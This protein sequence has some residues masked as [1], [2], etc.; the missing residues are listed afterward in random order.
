M[1]EEK[2]DLPTRVD[3]VLG[4]VERLA[5]FLQT[6]SRGDSHIA[7]QAGEVIAELDDIERELK[8]RLLEATFE[9]NRLDRRITRASESERE[10]RRLVAPHA[11]TGGDLADLPPGVRD[12]LRKAHR[13]RTDIAVWK[14]E[15]E[16]AEEAIRVCRAFEA[17]LSESRADLR[18]VLDSLERR[19]RAA[20]TKHA[21]ARLADRLRVMDGQVRGALS[22]QVDD[23]AAGAE[24]E[25]EVAVN[26]E[27]LRIRELYR[28]G[29]D[30]AMEEDLRRLRED[31]P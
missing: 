20:E 23:A 30:A 31:P 8:G 25:H 17:L 10:L 16:E 13:L 27:E 28:L 1:T 2:R 21:L 24:A 19:F 12:A 26:H 6:A 3:D 29:E 18:R 9:R 4:V 7:S 22:E 11:R 14:D 5:R 15:L